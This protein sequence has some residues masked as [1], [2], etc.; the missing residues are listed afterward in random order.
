MQ[1]FKHNFLMAW[2]APV[3]FTWLAC[4]LHCFDL[5]AV[6]V[7]RGSCLPLCVGEGWGMIVGGAG[8]CTLGG[9]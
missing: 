7:G 2:L 9:W 8:K 3:G 4:I 1:L 6:V 5:E